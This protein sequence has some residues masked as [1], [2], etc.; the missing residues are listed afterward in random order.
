MSDLGKQADEEENKKERFKG[1]FMPL[2]RW[3]RNTSYSK[4]IERQEA[5]WQLYQHCDCDACELWREEMGVKRCVDKSCEG[6]QNLASGKKLFNWYDYNDR[7]AYRD[8]L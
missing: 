4:I 6:C 1:K 2:C 3:N 7:Q 5:G 8:K